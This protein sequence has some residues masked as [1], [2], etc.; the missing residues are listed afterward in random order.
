MQFKSLDDLAAAYGLQTEA[1]AAAT[2][3]LD[4]LG[5]TS[6]ISKNKPTSHQKQLSSLKRR[7]NSKHLTQTLATGLL[8]LPGAHNPRAYANTFLCA[9]FVVYEDNQF[10]SK[11]CKN[12][13]CLVCNRI[14]TA[15]YIDTYEPLL[16][17]LSD[18]YF[19][20][21]TAPNVPKEALKARLNEYSEAWQRV[22]DRMRKQN[23]KIKGMRKLEITFNSERNDYHPHYH[24]YIEG[25]AQAQKL[26]SYWLEEFEDASPAAQDQQPAT[27]GSLK[28]LFK[29][30]TK[31][32]SNS[33]K[34]DRVHLP[35]LDTIFENVKG[36]RVFQSFGITI[37]NKTE[38][39]EDQ[40]RLYS[41]VCELERDT[42]K[43]YDKKIDAAKTPAVLY[44]WNHSAGNWIDKD[45]LLTDYIVTPNAK[46]FKQKLR[47]TYDPNEKPVRI[48]KHKSNGPGHANP[49]KRLVKLREMVP[50]RPN[51]PKGYI[52]ATESQYHIQT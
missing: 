27:P 17:K 28:E 3:L 18:P 35:A 9:G 48:T 33:S 10:K 52:S 20:T 16:K 5:I 25:K 26:V 15:Y 1:A 36:R 2:P 14:K 7:A 21:L 46:A 11:Y 39:T 4:K 38:I 30:F 47:K 49:N 44:I 31:I 13:W 34:D 41:Q 19:V 45:E 29:Y 32:T 40:M 24:I 8:N 42:K 37:K 12:R 6:E 51:E 50:K 22:K 23:I 43:E